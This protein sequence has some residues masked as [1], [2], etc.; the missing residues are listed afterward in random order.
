MGIAR[1]LYHNPEILFMDEATSALDNETEKEIMKA[2]DEL[3]G[4]KTLIIIA[5]RLST[6]ENCDIVYRMN[7]GKVVATNNQLVQSS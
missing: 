3:K 5:H 1:A 2:I 6:I 4:E 7:N